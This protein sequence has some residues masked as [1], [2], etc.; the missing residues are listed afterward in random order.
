[1]TVDEAVVAEHLART[2]AASGVPAVLDDETVA[3]VV[4][5]LLD[6]TRSGA[7]QGATTT[8]TTDD[9]PDATKRRKARRGR[10]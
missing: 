8:N 9:R 6:R 2:R 4:A 10:G 5:G 7:P 3:D 1:V